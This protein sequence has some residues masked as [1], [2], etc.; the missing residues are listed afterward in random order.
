MV[1]QPDTMSQF[2]NKIKKCGA[3]PAM[4]FASWMFVSCGNTQKKEATEAVPA[5]DTTEQALDTLTVPDSLPAIDTSA[6]VR[7]EPRKTR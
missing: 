3:L 5:A 2:T 6:K 4:L 1:N 7:P